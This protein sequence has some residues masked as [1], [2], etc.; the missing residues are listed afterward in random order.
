[1]NRSAIAAVTLACGA[2]AAIAGCGG[3]GGSSATSTTQGGTATVLMGTAP[4][5][6]DPQ[7]GYTTQSAE[8]TW[9]TYTPLLTYRHASGEPGT[10]LIP[11]LARALPQISSDGKTYKLQLRSGLVFSNGQRVK[12]SDFAYTIER[13]IKLNWGGKSFITG[14][15]AGASAYDRGASTTRSRASGPTT[16]PA[17]SR[18]ISPSPTARSATCWRSRRPAWSRAARR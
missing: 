4:D 1:M 3:S 18:S 9:I 17:G 10:Q 7:E 13:A 14:Y 15:V 16:R 11:G 8:A 12:A 5:F 2:A 6:L